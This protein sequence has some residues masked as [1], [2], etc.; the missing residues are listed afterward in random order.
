[1]RIEIAIAI[2]IIW[3][4]FAIPSVIFADVYTGIPAGGKIY[5]EIFPCTLINEE[6]YYNCNRSLRIVIF[7]TRLVPGYS[8]L[9]NEFYFNPDNKAFGFA[10][11][12]RLPLSDH[13]FDLIILGKQSMGEVGGKWKYFYPLT[14]LQHELKHIICHCNFHKWLDDMDEGIGKNYP[15]KWSKSLLR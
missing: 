14:P 5:D 4:S 7:D 11:F 8:S 15:N 1:M 3:L 9:F 6:P 2:G 13:P 12:K 10:Y